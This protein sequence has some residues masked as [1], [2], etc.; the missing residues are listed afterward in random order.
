MQV[1]D[2]I[3]SGELPLAKVA[4]T[5]E[6]A[7]RG[8][9]RE[10]TINM[11]NLIEVLRRHRVAIA[12]PCG[13]T[14]DLMYA[15]LFTMLRFLSRRCEVHIYCA[16]PG[17]ISP[18][19]IELLRHRGCTVR[20][21]DEALE[22]PSTAWDILI[23]SDADLSAPDRF[24]ARVILA[25]SEKELRL[26]GLALAHTE[27][28]GS[29]PHAPIAQNFP[30]VRPLDLIE[31]PYWG[32]RRRLLVF[33]PPRAASRAVEWI[34]GLEQCRNFNLIKAEYDDRRII[35]FE[36]DKT[37]EVTAR[38]HGFHF[39]RVRDQ[40]FDGPWDFHK[41]LV[42]LE[43]FDCHHFPICSVLMSISDTR[44]FTQDE[45]ILTLA[46]IVCGADVAVRRFVSHEHLSALLAAGLTHNQTRFGAL[47]RYRPNRNGLA[48]A[49][50]RLKRALIADALARARE[51]LTAEP[52]DSGG[53]SPNAPPADR[54]V[55]GDRRTGGR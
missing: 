35:A 10:Y 37:L 43:G 1:C 55:G 36:H 39:A 27:R 41:D 4:A 51:R 52:L 31:R 19:F 5:T 8:Y 54:A 22:E 45:S 6:T 34:G 53:L 20:L 40:L 15:Y 9:K 16:A 13:D 23:H 26:S 7:I 3:V 17:S 24:P 38:E 49:I 50:E 42:L 30:S 29:N 48:P 18:N 44:V 46:K 12:I 33:V 14:T 2:Q 28:D 47:T 32:P 11:G 25:C 21:V